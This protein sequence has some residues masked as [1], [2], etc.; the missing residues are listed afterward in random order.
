M[1]TIQ[2]LPNDIPKFWE[3][4]KFAAK[5]ADE[6]ADSEFPV[7]CGEMLHSLLNETSQCFIRLDDENKLIAIMITRV[8]VNK[9]SG[10]KSLFIQC[11][12][13]W[14]VVGEN[15]WMKDRELI[16]SY[17]KQ[18]GCREIVFQ[19]RHERVWELGRGAG[20]KEKYRAYGVRL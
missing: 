3:A 18:S 20:F 17:A 15:V 16:I 12:Y 19:S 7:Y 1:K 10:A 8:D 14:A 9:F 4:I 13:S 6:V 11:L 5:E 2:L